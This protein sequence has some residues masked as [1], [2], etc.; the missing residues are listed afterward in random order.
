MQG[1]V[2][3]IQG[4]VLHIQGIVLHIQGIVLHIQGIML[5]GRILHGCHCVAGVATAVPSGDVPEPSESRE[6][7]AGARSLSPSPYP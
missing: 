6:P 4:I 3:H 7:Q 5:H 1:I 2:L